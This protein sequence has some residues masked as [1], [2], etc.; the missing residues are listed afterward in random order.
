MQARRWLIWLTGVFDPGIELTTGH[1][2]PGRV[3]PPTRAI[4]CTPSS[5]L[6]LDLAT[7]HEGL[8][9]YNA[10][11]FWDWMSFQDA[12]DRHE[13]DGKLVRRR[14]HPANGYL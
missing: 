7:A 10:A 2:N 12:A 6:A 14:T 9:P 3:R 11:R 1:R 5:T 8:S 13:I 4:I